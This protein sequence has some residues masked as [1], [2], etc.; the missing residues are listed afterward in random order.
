MRPM[1]VSDC[2]SVKCCLMVPESSISAS[3]GAVVPAPRAVKVAVPFGAGGAP[4][5]VATRAPHF[6][7]NLS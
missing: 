5:A 7:Q 6:A 4:V 3:L 1:V 2:S